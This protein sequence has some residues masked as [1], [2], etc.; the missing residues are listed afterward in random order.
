MVLAGE[1][2]MGELAQAFVDLR[3]QVIDG[4]LVAAAGLGKQGGDVGGR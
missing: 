3:Q 4:A 2:A 1:I